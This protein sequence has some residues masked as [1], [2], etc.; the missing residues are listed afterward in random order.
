M[1]FFLCHIMNTD[2]LTALRIETRTLT[3]KADLHTPVGLFYRLRDLA[4]DPV[5]LESS[6][7]HQ[8]QEA[9]SFI[10]VDPLADFCLTHDKLR[11]RFLKDIESRPYPEHREVEALNEWKDS[12]EIEN[13]S[14]QEI[15]SIFG[16]TS[17]EGARLDDQAVQKGDLPIMQYRLYRFVIAFD[18][19]H[20]SLTIVENRPDGQVSQM[21]RILHQLDR[22]IVTPFPLQISDDRSSDASEEDFLSMV[23]NGKEHCQRGDVFQVV[24]SRSFT[25]SYK[26]DEFQLYR[27]LR[28]LNPSPYMFYFDMGPFTVLGASPEAQLLIEEDRASLFPIAGTFRRTGIKEQDDA[29]AEELLKD[30]KEHSEHVMLVDLARND[31][32]RIC[33]GVEVDYFKKVQSFSHVIHLTSKVSGQLRDRNQP[34]DNL[35]KTFPAGTLSGAPKKRAMEIIA[36]QEKSPR[37]LYGGMIGMLHPTGNVRHAI[38]IRSIVCREGHMTYRAGAGIVID[39]EPEKELQ[40]VY[41]KIGAIE[42]AIESIKEEAR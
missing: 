31:L 25:R 34:M 41:N 1:G 21:D 28:S 26:G 5:L 14:S 20:N 17:Y 29:A 36:E 27:S 12:F 4:P 18:H 11:L 38:F 2:V 42:K 24:L 15:P 19:H 6:E 9:H 32:N 22:G 37:G 40:E 35:I 23:K 39:S 10:G 7:R 30:P 33:T 13:S 8:T 3:R 16:F